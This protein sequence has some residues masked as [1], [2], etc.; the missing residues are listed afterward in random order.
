MYSKTYLNINIQ[1]FNKMLVNMHYYLKYAFFNPN[2]TKLCIGIT[3]N[4][5]RNLYYHVLQLCQSHAH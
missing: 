2:V 3:S 5:T 1:L 4:I